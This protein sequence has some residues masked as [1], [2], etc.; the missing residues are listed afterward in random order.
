ML[1]GRSPTQLTA[2]ET[3][4]LAAALAQLSGGGGGF[5]LLG[6]IE[7]ALGLDTFDIGSGAD[8]GTQVTSGKYLTDNVYLEVRSGAAGAPGVAIEWEPFNNIEVEAATGS[9]QGQQ[10][11]VQWKRDFDDSLFPGVSGETSSDDST[12]RDGQ[13]DA[14]PGLADINEG[15]EERET[16]STAADTAVRDSPTPLEDETN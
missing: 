3:A 16:G 13:P 10:L 11:S 1:F 9:E 14:D 8:G 2:L 6:G 12:L 5:N 4:R 15:E 7:Q